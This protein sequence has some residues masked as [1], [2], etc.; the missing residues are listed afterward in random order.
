MFSL[1]MYVSL[2][3]GA[4]PSLTPRFPL[5][6]M[7]HFPSVQIHH[8]PRF[9]LLCMFHFPSVQIHHLHLGFPYYVCFTSLQCKSITYTS[10]SLTMYVSLPFGANPSLTPR[11]PLL[12][13]FHF[14]LVQIHHLH[15]GFSY[16]VCFTSLHFITFGNF[17]RNWFIPKNILWWG[18]EDG[19]GGG[20]KILYFKSFPQ[21]VSDIQKIVLCLLSNQRK[22]SVAR[23]S[24]VSFVLKKAQAERN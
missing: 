11:F 18:E 13:M 24:I 10:V 2:T 15:L 3:F 17:F 1:T 4:N 16:Y 23:L 14:P 22:C 6:C 20:N 5:L 12:C 9:P 19:G 21:V 7:F 8:L